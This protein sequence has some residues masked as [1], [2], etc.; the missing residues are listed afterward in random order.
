MAILFPQPKRTDCVKS[1]PLK[2]PTNHRNAL[3]FLG[4][5]I[6]L[7]KLRNFLFTFASVRFTLVF[8]YLMMTHR[9]GNR[10]RMFG[11]CDLNLCSGKYN[12]DIW[13][14]IKKSG[15]F[16]YMKSTFKVKYGQMPQDKSSIRGE[17]KGRCKLPQREEASFFLLILM[18]FSPPLTN[19]T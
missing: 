1:K 8:L 19:Q 12:V 14:G 6:L 16:I 10:E 11:K 3:H 17:F 9:S 18:N 15:I 4:S 2:N 5:V 13:I 7:M